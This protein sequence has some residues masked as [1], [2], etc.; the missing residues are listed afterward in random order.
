MRG[1]MSVKGVGRR[2]KGEDGERLLGMS[3]CFVLF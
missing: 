1:M 3:E 2:D